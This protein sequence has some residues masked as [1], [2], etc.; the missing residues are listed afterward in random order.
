MK[1]K[2]VD[3]LIPS[4][5]HEAVQSK[6]SSTLCQF[7]LRVTEVFALDLLKEGDPVDL[8]AIGCYGNGY[9]GLDSGGTMVMEEDGGTGAPEN[10]GGAEQKESKEISAQQGG[11]STPAGGEEIVLTTQA[12]GATSSTAAAKEVAA[13]DK[14]SPSTAAGDVSDGVAGEGL[15]PE[16]K[17]DVS[18]SLP[19]K[20]TPADSTKETGDGVVKIAEAEQEESSL[21]AG[22]V[23]SAG[24]AE[25]TSPETPGGEGEDPA[26]G[27][28]P[29]NTGDPSKPA[30]NDDPSKAATNDDPSKP[31]T[32]DDPQTNNPETKPS[33]DKK[34]LL[35]EASDKDKGETTVVNEPE[36]LVNEQE[37]TTQPTTTTK[38]EEPRPRVYSLDKPSQPKQLS[39][40]P[41]LPPSFA[42]PPIEEVRAKRMRLQKVIEFRLRKV[43]VCMAQFLFQLWLDIQQQA[44]GEMHMIGSVLVGT[45]V[46]SL[47]LDKLMPQVAPLWIKVKAWEEIHGAGRDVGPKEAKQGTKQEVRNEVEEVMTT[48]GEEPEKTGG[49]GAGVGVGTATTTVGGGEEEARLEEESSPVEG[50]PGGPLTVAEEMEL[51][52][53]LRQFLSACPQ[54]NPP[55]SIDDGSKISMVDLSQHIFFGMF[56]TAQEVLAMMA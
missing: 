18:D 17:G 53:A 29:T 44:G 47:Y 13:V 10:G 51:V 55:D 54:G 45:I 36:N 40:P 39:L 35:E 42:P 52:D 11:N 6:V 20:V 16:A 15:T 24:A 26:A 30:T 7:Q 50:K 2:H 48:T 34:T 38:P 56:S 19:A 27:T 23:D 12:G 22:V 8:L 49:E 4:T 33:S 9:V 25:G 3:D 14:T 37:A 28:S 32:N 43:Q 41:S 1:M 21:G 5:C 46:H 31:A